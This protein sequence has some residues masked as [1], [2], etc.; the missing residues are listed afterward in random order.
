M[1]SLPPV[2]PD[3]PQAPKVGFLLLPAELRLCIY[4][5]VFANTH[6]LARKGER[7]RFSPHLVLLQGTPQLLFVCRTSFQE[8]LPV[9]WSEALLHAGLSWNFSNIELGRRSLLDRYPTSKQFEIHT[10]VAAIPERSRPLVRHLRH[11]VPTQRD[12]SCPEEFGECLRLLEGLRTCELSVRNL[13]CLGSFPRKPGWDCTFP[14]SMFDRL[15]SDS[16][17]ELLWQDRDV[18][19]PRSYLARWGVRSQMLEKCTFLVHFDAMQPPRGPPSPYKKVSRKPIL[20]RHIPSSMQASHL[21]LRAHS[22]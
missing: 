4:H 2:S 17:A 7:Q 20:Y 11:I 3:D 8:G 1:D 5:Y 13:N 12:Q 22:L 21:L 6:L 14:G 18:S 15:N 9:F 10:V 16:C 19:S